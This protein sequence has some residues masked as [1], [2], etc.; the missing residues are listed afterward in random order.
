MRSSKLFI[1]LP[2]LCDLLDFLLF[3]IRWSASVNHMVTSVA[4][5]V[6]NGEHSPKFTQQVSREYWRWFAERFI[7]AQTFVTY[8]N[9]SRHHVEIR[10]GQRCNHIWVKDTPYWLWKKGIGDIILK[11]A[12]IT[13]IRSICRAHRHITSRYQITDTM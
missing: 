3:S 5:A 8:V 1:L 13:S 6:S 11:F 10:Q 4:S 7:F 9:W 12:M 2:I